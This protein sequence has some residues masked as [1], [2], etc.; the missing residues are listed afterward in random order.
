LEVQ[1][2]QK[3]AALSPDIDRSI[4][5]ALNDILRSAPW[6]EFNEVALDSDQRKVVK[7]TKL[8]LHVAPNFK[9]LTVLAANIETVKAQAEDTE[10]WN[11][12]K[13]N[14]LVPSGTPTVPVS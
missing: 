14:S 13:D 10:L 2:G 11:L 5:P 4:I 6:K 9:V 8:T 3:V 1:N 12:Q 7:L